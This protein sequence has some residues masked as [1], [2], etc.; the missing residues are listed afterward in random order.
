MSGDDLQDFRE[1]GLDA[2]RRANLAASE[3]SGRAWECNHPWSLD[4]FLDFLRSFQ[5]IFEP[6]PTREDVGRGED[7]RL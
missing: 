5:E 1:E 4:D 6:F 2:E 7:F 3:A